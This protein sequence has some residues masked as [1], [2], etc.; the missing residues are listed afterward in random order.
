MEEYE[1]I[2]GKIMPQIYNIY[3]VTESGERI[4]VDSTPEESLR[5]WLKS[6]GPE[7]EHLVFVKEETGHFIEMIAF[8][9]SDWDVIDRGI[10]PLVE[11]RKSFKS[12]MKDKPL[13]QKKHHLKASRGINRKRQSYVPLYRQISH[14]DVLPTAQNILKNAKKANSGAWRL[15]GRQVAEIAN[16]YKFHPP[17][18]KKRSKHLGSTG[19]LMWRKGPKEYYLVKFSKHRTDP[20]KR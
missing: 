14:T 19:I 3:E 10:I 5:D 4:P 18:A 17:N 7:Y 1:K 12:F 2:K 16:K 13:D 9:E 15:S 8:G 11:K 6:I 20:T